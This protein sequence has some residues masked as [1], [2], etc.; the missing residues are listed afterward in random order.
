[1]VFRQ[2]YDKALLLYKKCLENEKEEV[3]QNGVILSEEDFTNIEND[4]SKLQLVL[5]GLRDRTDPL[6]A[7]LR[8]RLRQSLQLIRGRDGKQNAETSSIHAHSI[9]SGNSIKQTVTKGIIRNLFRIGKKKEGL[10]LMK[11]V[12]DAFFLSDCAKI[13]ME[14]GVCF[15]FS[16]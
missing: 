14:G 1:M 8:S 2:E 7:R 10:E 12:T 5:L 13:F 11:D 9:D 15:Y 6:A 16:K 3:E 4:E